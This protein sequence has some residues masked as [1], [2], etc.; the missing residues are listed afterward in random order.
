MHCIIPPL[1][2]SHASFQSIPKPTGYHYSNVFNIGLVL[3]LPEDH[4]NGIIQYIFFYVNPLSFSMFLRYINVAEHSNSSFL[5]LNSIP[6]MNLI[7]YSL[8]ILLTMYT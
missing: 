8:A 5:L 4:I 7:Q 3:P 2:F 1:K 6:F